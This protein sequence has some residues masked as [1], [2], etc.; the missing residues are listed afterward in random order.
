MGSHVVSPCFPQ[1]RDVREANEFDR[2]TKV[3]SDFPRPVPQP[4]MS[5]RRFCTCEVFKEVILLTTSYIGFDDKVY[6]VTVNPD[7]SQ[8]LSGVASE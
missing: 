7:G 5:E 1:F 4:L 8:C 6:T 3:G 2:N